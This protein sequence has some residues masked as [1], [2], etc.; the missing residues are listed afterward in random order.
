MGGYIFQEFPKWVG[1][2]LVES[3]A[4]ERAHLLV[5]RL[6]NQAACF[7]QPQ[8]GCSGRGSGGAKASGRSSV[9]FRP[10]RSKPWLRPGSSLLPCGTLRP[11]WRGVWVD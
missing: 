2:V 4:D 6:R 10:H 9:T 1:D 3:A 11:R 7:R 5:F 8:F